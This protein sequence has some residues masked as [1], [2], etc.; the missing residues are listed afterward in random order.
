MS[1]AVVPKYFV[2]RTEQKAPVHENLS[3]LHVLDSFWLGNRHLATQEWVVATDL[4]GNLIAWPDADRAKLP[5]TIQAELTFFEMTCKVPKRNLHVAEI[6]LFYLQMLEQP[7]P[8]PGFND[9]IYLYG[10][11]FGPFPQAS[12]QPVSGIEGQLTVTRADL[13]EALAQ[14]APYAFRYAPQAGAAQHSPRCF[15]L[16][17]PADREDE[18]SQG[19]GLV[20]AYP[21]LPPEL[22]LNEVR[23]EQFVKQLAYDVLSAL[24]EDLRLAGLRLPLCEMT[25]PVPSRAQLEQD[26]QAEGY[27][28]KGDT[29]RKQ[30][31]VSAQE[32][33]WLRAVFESLTAE[34]LQLPPEGTI[35]DYVNLA[36]QTLAQLPEWPSARARAIRER[37]TA[38]PPNINRTVAAVRSAPL[39]QPALTPPTEP[40]RVTLKPVERAAWIEDFIASHQVPGQPA[41]RLTTTPLINRDATQSTSWQEDFAPPTNPSKPTAK[42]AKQ[43]SAQPDWMKDFE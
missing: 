18:L 40:P 8:A 26:L 42:P 4:I 23:N 17:L 27:E 6:Y 21:L 28:I 1:H 9:P 16:L 19:R 41:P 20:L 29:A 34:Q 13:L 35:E 43:Q 39:T 5:E 25:L 36:A 15:H 7:G 11:L 33:G 3:P 10:T 30:F 22:I 32:Q 31:Q 38:M 12:A 24:R 14:N 2:S 37:V